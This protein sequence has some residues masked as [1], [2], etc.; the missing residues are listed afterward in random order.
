MNENTFVD[1]LFFRFNVFWLHLF[2]L[3][4]HFC[5]L[6]LFKIIRSIV[7]LL[8]T[9][10]TYFFIE[11]QLKKRKLKKCFL[12][13]RVWAFKPPVYWSPKRLGYVTVNLIYL[14]LCLRLGLCD[15]FFIIIFTFI[16][17]NRIISLKQ[18]HLFFLEH[19]LLIF[20]LVK[21]SVSGC[22]LCVAFAYF[23]FQFQ[24]GVAYKSVAFLKTRVVNSLKFYQSTSSCLYS[25]KNRVC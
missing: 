9:T 19:A 13:A 6:S 7:K 3:L 11:T 21:K 2:S 23:F 22:W 20:F 5:L 16:I 14:C 4:S 24:P 1:S 25:H 8:I 18:I 10:S 15:L 12:G 17:I